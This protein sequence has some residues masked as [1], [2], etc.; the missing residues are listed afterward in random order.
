MPKK[1][2]LIVDDDKDVCEA[3]EQFLKKRGFIA[4]KACDGKEASVA[5]KK[6]KPDLIILDVLMP[7]MDGFEFLQ[8]LKSNVR[9]SR[10]P[11][12]MLT[13]KSDPKHL[14]KGISLHA[15]FY[16]PKPFKFDNLMDFINIVLN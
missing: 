7:V 10:I 2:I 16:L 1:N 11:V 9:Y 13:V 3:I 5:L 14:E 8:F 12:I 15:D 6:Q 4:C